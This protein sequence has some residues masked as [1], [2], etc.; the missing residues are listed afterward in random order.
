MANELFK[1]FVNEVMKEPNLYNYYLR[2]PIV[3]QERFSKFL[4]SQEANNKHF[5]KIIRDRHFIK[6]SDSVVETI[7]SPD[8]N[9][10][11]DYLNNSNKTK[12]ISGYG[13]IKV[14]NETIFDI[15]NNTCYVTNGIYH[16]TEEIVYMINNYIFG[17]DKPSFIIGVVDSSIY[18]ENNRKLNSE[19]YLDNLE[20]I[21]K[22]QSEFHKKKIKV[23]TYKENNGRYN[24]YM[25]IHRGDSK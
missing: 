22:I 20:K 6:G 21:K 10:I 4:H 12:I 3:I 17:L 8:V 5:A 18:D 2:N 11:S 14:P 16:N 24:A 9:G 19:F 7:L 1:R 25:L 23:S 15:A 13:T